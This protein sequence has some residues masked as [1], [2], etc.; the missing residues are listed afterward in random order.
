MLLASVHLYLTPNTKIFLA[1][2]RFVLEVSILSNNK[3]FAYVQVS[4]EV[5]ADYDYKLLKK[6]QGKSIRLLLQKH[7]DMQCLV[8]VLSSWICNA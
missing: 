7:L 8:L 5:S 2:Q 4:T 3:K 6:N 1:I